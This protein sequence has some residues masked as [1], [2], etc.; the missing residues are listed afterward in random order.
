MDLVLFY[1]SEIFKPKLIDDMF[2]DEA[3]ILKSQ[4]VNCYSINLEELFLVESI[5]YELSGKKVL[6][7][8]W[9]LN[10]DEYSQLTKLVSIAHGEMLIPIKMFLLAHHLPNWYQYIQDFTAK[11]VIVNAFEDL[12]SLSDLKWGKFM[13]KDYVKSLKTSSGPIIDNISLLPQLIDEMRKFRGTI[14]GG[15]CVREYEDYIPETEVRYFVA[16][17]QVFAPH[18]DEIPN[19][20]FECVK[21]IQHQ[22][23]SIDVIKTLDSIDRIV[24]IG[25][26]QVSDYVG[27]D[28]NKFTEVLV[29]IK[30]R[31][32][33]I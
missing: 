14:E 13:I 7:R 27:W 9:M 11:T 32:S 29:F 21:R 17:G 10:S 1:P 20:V 12:K 18:Q 25:D 28:L 19:I 30:S 4:G 3:D 24:E 2:R 23:F 16:Y 15:I 6:Y 33:Y 31:I 26:G 8:G 22:F 5:P